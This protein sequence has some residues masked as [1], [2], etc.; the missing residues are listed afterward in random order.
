MCTLVSRGNDEPTGH[1]VLWLIVV[2]AEE[3]VYSIR[4]LRNPIALKKKL[5]H[6]L[7]RV[8]WVA[9][10]FCQNYGMINTAL[11]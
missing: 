3:A 7:S 2:E 10:S 4:N 1:Q 11:L 6:H 8:Q 5:R 9:H